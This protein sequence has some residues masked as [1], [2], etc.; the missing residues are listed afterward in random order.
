MLTRFDDAYMRYS[1]EIG[2]AIESKFSLSLNYNYND[3]GEICVWLYVVY[4]M[5]KYLKDE[6]GAR[7]TYIDPSN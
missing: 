1:G 6:Y 4:G 3:V 2:R 7:F 5:N